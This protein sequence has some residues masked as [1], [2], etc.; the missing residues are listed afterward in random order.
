MIIT[1]TSVDNQILILSEVKQLLQL[2]YSFLNRDNDYARSPNYVRIYFIFQTATSQ[3]KGHAKFLRA[4]IAKILD[5]LESKP[6]IKVIVKDYLWGYE[7][8]LSK[9][10]KDTVTPQKYG[11]LI[12]VLKIIMISI[13]TKCLHVV[14]VTSNSRQCLLHQSPNL[15]FLRYP[16]LIQNFNMKECRK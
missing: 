8:A 3:S 12:E 5:K 1:L 4:T 7:D 14:I 15:G 6:F 2:K 10:S 9:F 11:V 13:K 16:N